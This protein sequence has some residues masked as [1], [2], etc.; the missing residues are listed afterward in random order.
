MISDGRGP[1]VTMQQVL[2]QVERANNAWAQAGI[3]VVMIDAPIIEEAPTGADGL[4]ILSDG[5]LDISPALDDVAVIEALGAAATPAVA[6]VIYT[7][8]ITGALGYARVPANMG[9]DLPQNHGE[10]TYLFVASNSPTSRRSLAH[11]IGHALTNQP[12]LFFTPS[13]IFPAAPPIGTPQSTL[14]DMSPLT[15]RRVM[16]A[17]QEAARTDRAAGCLTCVGNRLL[18]P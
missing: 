8:P 14:L 3:R 5:W 12:D 1:V 9:G 7:G 13:I 2:D 4:N 11:E 6:E 18:S 15:R 17:T 10:N 16:H